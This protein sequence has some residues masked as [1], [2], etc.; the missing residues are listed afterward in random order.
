MTSRQ[1]SSYELNHLKKH[2]I[3]LPEIS[4]FGEMPVEYITGHADFHGLDFLVNQHT[5]IPRLESEK[6]VD[7]VL[8]HIS[9]QDL[10]HP[11]IADI[12]TGSGCLG[13]TIAHYLT[14]Q[15]TPYTIYLSDVSTEALN[16]A[17]QN[18]DKLLPSRVNLFFQQSNLMDNY[19]KIKFD[20]I[21]ANL[22]YIPSSRISHLDTSVKDFEP[23]Q[24]LDGGPKGTILINRLLPQLPQFL[25]DQ[26]LAIL[27][28]DDTQKLD[29]FSIPQSLSAH[30]ENDINDVPRFLLIRPKP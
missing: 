29:D 1:F 6:I 10:N 15:Q 27:E 3:N 24:A 23:I 25:T 5:L 2:G 19:P 16:I 13:I 14:G 22:P 30:I 11:A 17:G 26:G 12:G 7:L 4:A 18:A 28:F 21:V 8:Q 20:I 9:Q